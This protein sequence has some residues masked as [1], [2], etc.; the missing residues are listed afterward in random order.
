MLAYSSIAQ[1]GYVLVGVAAAGPN[2]VSAVLFYLLAY[3][4]TNLAAF[5]AVI[6]IIRA[7]GSEQIA[8]FRGLHQREPAL[9]LALAVSLF[10]LAGLPPFVGFFAKLYVFWAAAQ[11]GLLWLVLIAV[12][13][14]AISLYYYAQVVHDM[15]LLPT[16]EGA[17]GR[18]GPQKPALSA[19]LSLGI[20]VAGVLLL[21]V[22]SGTFFSLQ[23]VAASAI[24]R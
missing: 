24:A 11:N 16:P 6:G 8:D 19:T 12:I 23:S 2:G 5:I 15:Y 22:L 10:S 18:I 3:T 4:A 20:A 13:N 21:G 14:S 17:E 9:A 1:A 7:T